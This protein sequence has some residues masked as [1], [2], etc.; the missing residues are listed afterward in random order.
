MI[1][2]INMHMYTQLVGNEDIKHEMPLTSIQKI[3]DIRKYN[4]VI[5]NIVITVLRLDIICDI[6]LCCH[7]VGIEASESSNIS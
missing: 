7:L 1:L 2:M 4:K 5:L 6:Y 3:W